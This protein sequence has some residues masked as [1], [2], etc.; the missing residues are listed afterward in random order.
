MNIVDD[1]VYI[2]HTMYRALYSLYDI[3]PLISEDEMLSGDSRSVQI[4][5]P[6]TALYRRVTTILNSKPTESKDSTKHLHYQGLAAHG[7][8]NTAH[9]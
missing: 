2:T 9:G 4:P 7:L 3:Y 6:D 8:H 1:T 5:H